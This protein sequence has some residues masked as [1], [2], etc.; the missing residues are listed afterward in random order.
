MLG[1]CHW[2]I[3]SI[4]EIILLNGF[5][6]DVY[7]EEK[8]ERP[9]AFGSSRYRQWT[10]I[11]RNVPEFHYVPV[12]SNKNHIFC[13]MEIYMCLSMRFVPKYCFKL[14]F[15]F[16]LFNSANFDSLESNFMIAF[17]NVILLNVTAWR[18]SE[19]SLYLPVKRWQCQKY[20]ICSLR[21]C[22][23]CTS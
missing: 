18:D 9:L 2:V 21:F 3:I 6:C 23:S 10:I 15:Y 12:H 14:L 16:S 13:F 1:K 11:H 19:K 20:V 8:G 5:I 4:N 7:M 22:L 17:A